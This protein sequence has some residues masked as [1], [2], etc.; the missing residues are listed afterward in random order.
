[1]VFVGINHADITKAC[2]TPKMRLLFQLLVSLQP[3]WAPFL[4]NMQSTKQKVK[5]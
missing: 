1:M 3:Q 2:K 5:K 4:E